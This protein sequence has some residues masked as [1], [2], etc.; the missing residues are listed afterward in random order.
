M[1]GTLLVLVF[2]GHPA[3]TVYE[4]LSHGSIDGRDLCRS[5]SLGHFAG[6]YG[7]LLPLFM[8]HSAGIRVNVMVSLMVAL[9]QSL[10]GCSL[11]LYVG[12]HM[13]SLVYVGHSV[14]T[15]VGILLPLFMGSL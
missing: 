7:L 14:C 13:G 12:H 9:W 2:R 10:W 5:C 1:W 11:T 3:D 4:G 15:R 8:G 6:K